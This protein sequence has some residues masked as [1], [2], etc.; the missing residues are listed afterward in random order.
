MDYRYY[1]NRKIRA[2]IRGIACGTIMLL[3]IAG[4]WAETNRFPTVL[5]RWC[6]S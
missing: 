2:Y 4:T 5:R 1:Q 3:I 6:S